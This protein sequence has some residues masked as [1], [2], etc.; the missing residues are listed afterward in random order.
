MTGENIPRLKDSRNIHGYFTP[1]GNIFKNIGVDK[2]SSLSVFRCKIAGRIKRMVS[3]QTDAEN[4]CKIDSER[5]I[6]NI[7]LIINI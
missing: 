3:W 5:K 6:I 4:E 2:N 1:K 7:Y